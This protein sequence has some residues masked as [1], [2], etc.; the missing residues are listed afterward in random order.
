MNIR[1]SIRSKITKPIFALLLIVFA[2][3]CNFINDI[4]SEQP[5]IYGVDNVY[6]ELNMQLFKDFVDKI[7]LNDLFRIYGE[8]DTILNAYTVAGKNGY[9]I[10]EY[11]FDEGYIDCY[12]KQ[13]VD[14]EEAIVD[15]IYFEPFS[16]ILLE[17]L[18]FD[19]KQ[20]EIIRQG[21]TSVYYIVDDFSNYVRFRLSNDNRNEILNVALNDITY[22]DDMKETVSYHVKDI[23]ESIPVSIRDF[24]SIYKVEY[25]E[26]VLQLFIEV[27]ESSDLDVDDIVQQNPE[28]STILAIQL[29]GHW[30]IFS[31]KTCDMIREHASVKFILSGNH[32]NRTEEATYRY[33]DL[34]KLFT[35]GISN[36]DWLNNNVLFE[37]FNLPQ[38]VNDWVILEKQRIEDS[39]LIMPMRLLG[40]NTDFEGLTTKTRDLSLITNSENPERDYISRCA[41]CK[42]GFKKVYYFEEDNDTV[43]V[44]YSP[45]EV[46]EILRTM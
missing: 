3:A 46:K 8:P 7:A 33:N 31:G 24:G 17:D 2:N 20:C 19:K 37:N 40:K 12:V 25:N 22:L 5:E 39:F 45:E 1:K 34:N 42:Y 35:N 23:Q 29:F 38:P 11:S 32:S 41:R 9:D 27:N 16:N 15:Y 18:I 14:R 6:K 4:Q 26:K 28:W 43:V 13:N 44:T 10:Y 30:G 36:I 21:E